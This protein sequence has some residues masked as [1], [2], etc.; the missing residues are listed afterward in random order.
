LDEETLTTVAVADGLTIKDL[1]AHI[2]AW[3]SLFADRI[4]QVVA[5]RTSALI[6]VDLD[7]RNAAL[8]EERRGWS[9]EQAV[10]AFSGERARFLAALDQV[11]DPLF[12][13]MLTLPWGKAAVRTWAEWRGRHDRSHAR[14]IER[15]RRR[16]KPPRSITPR[17]LLMAAFAAARAELL[18]T[19]ALVPAADRASRPLSHGWTL[20]DKLGHLADWDRAAAEALG[21]RAAGREPPSDPTV[22]PENDFDG[23]N[24]AHRAARQDQPWEAVWADFLAARHALTATLAALDDAAWVRPFASPWTP[25]DAAH[26]WVR[27]WAH[28]DREHAAE[29]RVGLGLPLPA[30]LTHA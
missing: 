20:K 28:H 29:I 18:A 25:D 12:H 30:R 3:D 10:A 9:L 16:T 19:A 14:E 11:P 26:E 4:E 1:L 15:W 13:Q 6:S 7:A 8:R 27:I 2:A 17:P 5:G 24:T 21:E 23:W 22:D